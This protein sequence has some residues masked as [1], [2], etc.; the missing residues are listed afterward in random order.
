MVNT[1]KKILN[2]ARDI[3]LFL[4]QAKIVEKLKI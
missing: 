2:F 1:E 3:K 4:C